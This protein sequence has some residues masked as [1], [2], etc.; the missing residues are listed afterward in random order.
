MRKKIF[1]FYRNNIPNFRG[2]I[3]VGKLLFK[4][5]NYSPNLK[6][7]VKVRRDLIYYLPSLRD[8]IG[9]EL[10][11]HGIYEPEIVHFIQKHIG[12]SQV[13]FDVGANIGSIGLPIATSKNV[14]Y[15]GFEAS[16]S[17][18]KYLSD[19]FLLNQTKDFYLANNA[20]ADM[21]NSQLNFADTSTDRFGEGHITTKS[22][23]NTI[24]IET[25]ALD[26]FC[27][28]RKISIIDWLKVD[29]QGYE[30]L[31]F[32]GA[33]KLL[34]RGSI[35]NILFE[36]EDWAEKDAGFVV[37]QAKLMISDFGYQLKNLNGSNWSFSD[38]AK[39]TMIWATKSE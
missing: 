1:D 33:K 21:S 7:P 36:F 27:E 6:D 37:G 13:F 34:Q 5:M 19:N 15:F 25:V 35:K 26:D 10:F 2:K 29:V 16:P 22:E 23:S 18:Y 12:D 17:V 32:E 14:R 3:R 28:N 39:S 11:F 8:Q 31:V 38:E 4:I 20:V 30:A 24:S 9:I